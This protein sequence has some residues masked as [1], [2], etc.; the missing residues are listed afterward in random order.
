MPKKENIAPISNALFI[1]LFFF[2]PA[3]LFGQGPGCPNVNAGPDTTLTC[4]SSCVDLNATMLETG[5]T[6]S[7]AVNSIPY[8]P[9][10]PFTGGTS[11]FIGQD[12]IWS[13]VINLP[14]TFCF[15][16]NTYSQ[17][18]VGANGLLSFNTGMATT[19][20]EWNFNASI[21]APG[22]PGAPPSGIYNNS[23][24]GAYHDIDPS[25]GWTGAACDINY[26][27]L[28]TAPCRTF[29][30]NYYEI[31]HYDPN[32][33][34]APCNSLE[35]TQQIVLY[36]TTNAIEVYIS[37]KPTCNSWNNGNAVIGLQNA[38]GTQ[39]ITPPGR[40]T[41][42]WSASNEAWRFIPDGTP[43]FTIEWYE[44]A[45][46]IGTSN[47][48]NVCPTVITD[49]VA[50]VT[51]TNCNGSVIVETDTVMVTP[52]ICGCS[53]TIPTTT[54]T[55][56]DG[57]CDGTATVS[58]NAGVPP[59]TYSWLP[60]GGTGPTGTG[61]CANTTYTVAVI[62]GNSD[63]CVSTVSVGSPLPVIATIGTTSDPTCAIVPD[64][65]AAATAFGGTGTYTYSWSPGGGS[66]AVA[67]G[68]SGGVLYTVTVW[69]ANGCIGTDTVTLNVPVC[70]CSPAIN[71]TTDPSCAGICDGSAT[72]TM[73]SGTPPFT[74]SWSHSGGVGTT[75][76]GLCADTV[77]SL[78]VIDGNS[79]TC[80]TSVQLVSPPPLSV[81]IVSYS[82]PSCMGLADG[83]AS[84][85]ATGGT[86]AY[87]YSWSPS[88]GYNQVAMGLPGD[89]TYTVTVWDANGCVN[90][91]T[92]TLSNPPSVVANITSFSNP[93][94]NTST[95]IASVSASGGT[96][97]YSYT[98]F[99]AGGNNSTGTGL[100]GGI[101]YTVEVV[102]SN[103]CTDSDSIVLVAPAALEVNLVNSSDP[104]C[105]GATDGSIDFSSNGGTG[106]YSYTWIPPVSS[107]SSASGLAGDTIYQVW[108]T[109]SAGC[110]DSILVMLTSPPPLIASLAGN[111]EICLGDTVKL[112]LAGSGGTPGYSYLWLQSG[113]VDSFLVAFPVS[114]T[115]YDAVVIDTNGCMDSAS[116][117]IIVHPL[118]VVAFDVDTNAGCVPLTVVFSSLSDSSVTC[119]WDIGDGVVDSCSSFSHTYNSPGVY[120]VQLNITDT[121][122]CVAGFLDTSY[123]H[124]FE[125]PTADFNADP[126]SASV[127]TPT[128][129][130]FD[131]STFSDCWVWDFGGLDSSIEQNPS[132]MFPSSDTGSFPVKL[133]VCSNNGCYDS[134]IKWISIKGEFVLFVPNSFTPNGD[135]IND[136]FSP[137]GMGFK[138]K[139]LKFSIFNRWGAEIFTSENGEPWNGMKESGTSVVQ[140]GVYV[141]MV[142][143]V[144]DWKKIHSA[145][146]HVTLLP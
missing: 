76:N 75:A 68:L 119:T 130:F 107:G 52:I 3:A 96:Q 98:W 1:Y 51:Y 57:I 111:D 24:N 73:T 11:I 56:C 55:T 25:V 29:V 83:M 133:W 94:C 70:T 5:N 65:V 124:V 67:T 74:Y 38:N 22:P 53:A 122:G 144:D 33:F 23:I 14:F 69:D 137:K 140:Q 127:N 30:V 128:I 112:S 131:Q 50:Q 2:L 84:V 135:G 120:D 92:I 79:D 31:P 17:I 35:T 95:G 58:V 13:S 100:L 44:G 77:Y 80:V 82:D 42:P 121:N 32:I 48:I 145:Y 15:Y 104:S 26:A 12:D 123:I 117:A 85:M 93:L 90:S 28:G 116:L 113:T 19:F 27:V 43:N 16:G 87:T 34:V 7:Y 8:S 78:T 102:D 40:N 41:G 37:N 10:F 4:A 45:N 6:S 39:G 72:V 91:D 63:T 136:L 20:C 106:T 64:G 88:G 110:Q 108:V 49:Y 105:D 36:E 9:P 146:G 115:I 101:S 46:M 21:P 99:P 139:D 126:W 54:N 125:T 66:G 60:T 59:Y 62:D 129:Q 18:I 103:G 118:P 97:P 61:L 142:R 141:W 132:Y 71:L 86:G 114:T 134:T 47:P 109:D 89:I 138:G 143:V 81:G